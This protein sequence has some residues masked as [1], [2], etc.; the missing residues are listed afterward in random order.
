[1]TRD[2]PHF[3][4]SAVGALLMSAG[5]LAMAKRRLPMTVHRGFTWRVDHWAVGKQAI[6]G[7]LWLVVIGAFITLVLARY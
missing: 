6:L 5:L 7:G 3:F 2:W 4:L 1:V